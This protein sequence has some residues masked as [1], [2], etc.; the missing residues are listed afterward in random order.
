MR[1]ILAVI[2]TLSSG[3]TLAQPLEGPG[4][5]ATS[6]A[7]AGAR[8]VLVKD[9]AALWSNPANIARSK[10]R[11]S[12]ALQ[13]SGDSRSVRL[14]GQAVNEY[15]PR[16]A[17]D[18]AGTIL[19]PAASL[20][21]PLWRDRLWL[22][23][24]YRIGLRLKSAYPPSGDGDGTKARADPGRYLGTELGLEQH[25]FSLGAAFRW[26]WLSFGA[27][28]ELSHLRLGRYRQT[29]WAGEEQD[30]YD[31]FRRPGTTEL[32]MDLLL[33]GSGTLAAGALFGLWFTPLSDLIEV[34][35]TL[36]LPVTCTLSGTATL[37]QWRNVYQPIASGNS[38]LELILPLRL[39]GGVAIDLKL[40]R[41]ALEAALA[42][43]SRNEE[44][45][46]RL[47]GVRIELGDGRA[48]NITRLPLGIQLR[49]HISA[50]L[51]VEVPLW[52]GFIVC[53]AGYAYHRGATPPSAPSATLVDLDHHELGVGLLLEAK[54]IRLAVAVSHAFE[55]TLAASG[56]QRRAVNPLD[57]EISESIGRG[58]YSS[59]ST[60]VV[61]ELQ[62]G[63]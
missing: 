39:R 10:S 17:R 55:A 1:I 57:P 2:L 54:Q 32:D 16:E 4:A 5:G 41:L 60:R 38:S 23:I 34:G 46:A 20:A 49:D 31:P 13:M 43:W 56:E 11:V 22:G 25:L 59:S 28:L 35:L 50:H 63:W 33:Q 29:L 26:S 42:R 7:M 48:K 44:I 9:P 15:D 53:R 3:S 47:E 19:A 8:T 36:Q 12:L 45:T 24:G 37:E 51:G 21:L 30:L 62:T 40:F 52:R 6:L 58:R 61:I 18:L 14:S 27:S